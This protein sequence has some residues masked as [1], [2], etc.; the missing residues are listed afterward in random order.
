MIN[1]INASEAG[2]ATA[3]RNIFKEAR[4]INLKENRFEEGNDTQA[5]PSEKYYMAQ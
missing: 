1:Q 5:L 4:N 3:W 2:L